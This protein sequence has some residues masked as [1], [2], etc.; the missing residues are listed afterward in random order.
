[1]RRLLSDLS[2]VAAL[3]LGIVCAAQAQFQSFPPGVFTGRAALDAASGGGGAYTGPGDAV[4]GA[5]LSLSV[6]AYSAATRGNKL[7]NVCATDL[8][9]CADFLSDATT[10]DLVFQTVN[11]NAC[12]STGT[13]VVKNWYDDSG[14]LGCAGARCDILS[15]LAFASLPLLTPS[16]TSSGKAC[17]TCNGN[18]FNSASISSIAQP[19][20]VST[21][22]RRTSGTSIS[23][24]TNLGGNVETFFNT[25]NTTGGYAGTTQTVALTDNTW[26]R[27]QATFN[28]ASGSLYVNGGATTKNMG[29]GAVSGPIHICAAGGTSQTLT[30]NITELLVY[31]LDFTTGSRASTM[32]TNQQTYFGT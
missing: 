7:M 31:P 15:A 2:F 30:G 18:D 8:A 3:L 11:G 29:V 27:Q 28:G 1:M 17:L 23:I 9:H 20:D 26:G 10:G 32:D 6:R 5:K 16:C 21:V 22:A 12:G 14:G 19:H 25:A 4:S 13:C 24:V